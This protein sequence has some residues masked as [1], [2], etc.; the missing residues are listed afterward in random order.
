MNPARPALFDPTDGNHRA[1][2]SGGE[3]AAQVVHSHDTGF[4]GKVE[5]CG[6]NQ[7]EQEQPH[8]PLHNF[9]RYAAEFKNLDVPLRDFIKRKGGLNK[10]AARFA[11]RLGRGRQS[12]TAYALRRGGCSVGVYRYLAGPDQLSPGNHT[13]LIDFNYDGGGI[14]KAAPLR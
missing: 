9:T 12:G 7:G 10:C 14:G 2:V 8:G 13:I 6:Q 4:V 1:G 5:Y 11:R 3:S